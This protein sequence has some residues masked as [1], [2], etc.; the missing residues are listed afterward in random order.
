MPIFELSLFGIRIAPTYYGTA[1]AVGFLL[2]YLILKKRAV[3][4]LGKLDDLLLY[5]FLGVFL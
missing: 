4:P 5:V 3:V 1:Y 2:G